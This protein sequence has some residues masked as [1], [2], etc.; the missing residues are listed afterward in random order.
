MSIKLHIES[1]PDYLV[2]IFSGE[3]AICEF[4]Q[5]FDFIAE[6]CKRLDKHK[7]LIDYRNAWVLRAP[8]ADR[9]DFG[10]KYRILA[11]CKL[12]IANLVIP[13]QIGPSRLVE[14]VAQNRGFI[15]RVFT[16]VQAAEGWLLQ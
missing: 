1:W 9:Y 3:G 16:N 7:L 13:K 4:W 14:L 12:K 5:Q 8:M 10:E 11:Q 2:A 6:Q 15:T